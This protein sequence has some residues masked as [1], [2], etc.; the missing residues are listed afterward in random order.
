MRTEP[1]SIPDW[2]DAARYA[3]LAGADRALFAWEWL[4]RDPAYWRAARAFECGRSS[5]LPGSGPGRFG[6]AAFEAPARAVPDARPVWRSEVHP[7]VLA[8]RAGGGTAA[9]DLFDLASLGALVRLVTSE[10]ADRLLL[11]DGFHSVRLDAPPGT[12]GNGPVHLTYELGGLV[13]AE[14]PLLTLRRFLALSG[15]GRFSR[16][17]HPRE[18]RARRW[19]LMLRAWD[20]LAAGADQRQIAHALLSRAAGDPQ[21]RSREPSVRS[22]VQRLV[23][24]GRTFAQGGFRQLLR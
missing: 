3:A 11:S 9:R 5:A 16:V 23:R 17:L 19:I 13:S 24:S 10:D 12:F 6:L 2:R 7:L 14:R 22:Q 21:W 15:A 18:P 4:R 1:A 20:A 8:A